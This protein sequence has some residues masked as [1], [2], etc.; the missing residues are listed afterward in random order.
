MVKNGAAIEPELC[1]QPLPRQSQSPAKVPGLAKSAHVVDRENW[2]AQL[3][4]RGLRVF[5]QDDLM[6]SL[7]SF[8]HRP[9]LQRLYRV[10]RQHAL[11]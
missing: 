1:S 8:C 2:F 6:R 10:R 9:Y 5:N 4:I 7:A 3:K 11:A